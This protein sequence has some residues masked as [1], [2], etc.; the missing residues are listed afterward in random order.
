MQGHTSNASDAAPLERSRPSNDPFGDA[1]RLSTPG[2]APNAPASSPPRP[3]SQEDGGGGTNDGPTGP[4]GA[5]DGS[6]DRPRPAI[7]D[8]PSIV[9]DRSESHGAGP[10]GD[11]T[12]RV[13]I[14]VHD[15]SLAV[16]LMGHLR[17]GAPNAHAQRSTDIGSA[18]ASEV[19]VAEVRDGA[20][21]AHLL[22]RI[23]SGDLDRVLVLDRRGEA[24]S[25]IAL[26]RAGVDQVL[27]QDTGAQELAAC[28]DVHLRHLAAAAG[29]SAAPA[30]LG[31]TRPSRIEVEPGLVVD[32]GRMQIERGGQS[33]DL[34]P[35]EAGILGHVIEHRDRVVAR[36]EI[37]E[38]VWGSRETRACARTVDVHV[39]A[40][41]RKLHGESG[42]QRLLRT[43]RGLGYR[44]CG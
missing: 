18:A 38:A 1:P 10:D 31:G 11:V 3:P 16:E 34:T 23:E 21:A 8:A 42:S 39:V 28:V 33:L 17:G 27:D 15:E 4:R 40:L 35:L 43:V 30:S 41:R 14:V 13:S 9:G 29:T 7:E 25:R 2:A 6:T 20:D 44:W 5:A 22:D 19:L 26:L 24:R 37:L 32:L 12:A 36:E